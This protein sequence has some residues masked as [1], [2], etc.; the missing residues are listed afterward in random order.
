MKFESNWR[1]KLDQEEER[2]REREREKTKSIKSWSFGCVICKWRGRCFTD[3]G[4]WGDW[5]P[6]ILPC[7][8]QPNTYFR[9]TESKSEYVDREEGERVSKKSEWGR[10]RKRNGEKEK[11]WEEENKRKKKDTK[12]ESLNWKATLD[13]LKVFFLGF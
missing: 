3:K 4:G 5:I 6:L 2:E 9:L 13:I 10:E 7:D 12:R 1:Q 8:L 11:N